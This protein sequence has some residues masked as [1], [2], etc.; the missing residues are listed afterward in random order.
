VW[1]VTSGGVDVFFT[2]REPGAVDGRRRHLCRVEEGGSIFTISGI[3]GRSGGGL[4]AVGAGPAQL[5]K[6][7]RGELI[8]LSFEEGLL[9]Q[10]ALLVDDW[11]VRVG[12]SLGPAVGDRPCRELRRD[13]IAALDPGG[14]F[15]VRGGV[16]WVRH[17]CGSSTFLDEV[18]LPVNELQARFPLTGHLWLTAST[19]S[20][21][22]ACDTATVIGSGDPWVG[23]D[24]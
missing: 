6:F 11:L 13:A 21:V 15:R 1:L 19:S 22:T 24:D 5:L 7:S 12:R 16:A 4:V 14:R 3:R 2:E 9:E 23:L 8:R 17:L 10:V 20:R 18:P